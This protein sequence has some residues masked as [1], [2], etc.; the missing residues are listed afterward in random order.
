M[1]QLRQQE[2][3]LAKREVEVLVVSFEAG[4]MAQAYVEDTELRWP[5]LV[6]ESRELY[7]AYGMLHGSRWDLWGPKTWLVYAK[8]LLRGR[9]LQSSSADVSQL[10]GDVL[11]DR[12]GTVRLHHVG[13][14]PA[15]RPS[16]SEIL[17]QIV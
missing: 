1:S 4:L 9:R 14:G 17:G 15:D 2:E 11:I 10:G 8:L 6:D 12:D 7:R 3:E 5:I 16:V 13:A